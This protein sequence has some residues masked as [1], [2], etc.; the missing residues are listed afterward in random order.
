MAIA[1]HRDHGLGEV[2]EIF[3]IESFFGEFGFEIAWADTV[4]SDA[5]WREFGGSGAREVDDGAFGGVI[6][7]GW[8]FGVANKAVHGCNVDD[9]AVVTL[10][11]E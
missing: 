4:T 1:A 8:D 2:L 7:D 5:I 6:G 10:F 3:G 9:A 11:H